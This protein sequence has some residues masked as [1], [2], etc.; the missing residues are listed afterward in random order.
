[1]ASSFETH[2]FAMLLG[3]RCETLMVRRRALRGVSN[4][5]ASGEGGS[6]RIELAEPAD[7]API[8]IRARA[9][10]APAECWLFSEIFVCVR[11]AG[12]ALPDYVREGAVTDCADGVKP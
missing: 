12:A 11:S 3:V 10:S 8:Q 4:H 2:R 6:R 5:E 9:W 7:S 1:M